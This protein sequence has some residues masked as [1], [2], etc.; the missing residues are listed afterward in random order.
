MPIQQLML[1]GTPGE[2]PTYVD[3]VFSTY[4]YKGNNSDKT[5]TN[6]IDLAGEGGLTWVKRTTGG[7]ADHALVDTLRGA[8]EL[9]RSN[10]NAA[11]STYTAGSENLSTFTS[12]GFTLKEDSGDNMF[13]TNNT[14]YLSWSFRRAPGFFDCMLYSG[15]N[16]SAFNLNHNLGVVPALIILKDRQYANKWYVWMKG[17]STNNQIWLASQ[18]EQGTD[19][20]YR[21]GQNAT[22]SSIQIPIGSEVN[23]TGMTNQYLAYVFADGDESGAQIFGKTGDQQ[24]TKS[25]TYTGDGST[26]NFVTVGFEP[27]WLLVREIDGDGNWQVVDSMRGVVTDGNDT[28]MRLNE[29][30]DN[31]TGNYL[32]FNPTG[33]ELTTSSDTYWNQDGK[34]YCYFAIRRPDGYVGKPPSS[35]TDVF[36]MDTGANITTIPPGNFDSGFPVDFA[37]RSIYQSVGDWFSASR[38]T[39]TGYMVPNNTDYEENNAAVRW[40]SNEGWSSWQ[41]N[42]T[43][44]SYMWKRHKGMD[45][46]TWTGDGST[47]RSINHT[48]NQAPEMIWC[49]VRDNITYRNWI[50]LIPG[51]GPTK[52]AYLN[53]TM[54]PIANIVVWRDFTPTSTIFKIGNAAEVNQNNAEYVAYLF[55][56]VSGICKCGSY[57]G[58]DGSNVTVDLGFVP[59]FIIIK[60]VGTGDWMLFDSTQGL[61][62]TNDPYKELNTNIASTTDNNYLSISGNSMI[63]NDGYSNTNTSTSTYAYYAHA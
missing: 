59:R 8:G 50:C 58:G 62:S 3:D 26:S 17:M 48:M 28:E 30:D 10:T 18:S 35:G 54:A 42:S 46:I 16:E 61:S 23:Y 44:L 45:V 53:T 60:K 43:Y 21:V 57:T 55:T 6:G 33:F 1:G 41:Q 49:K 63:I 36:T 40:D 51:A 38:L 25:G 22:S 4:L 5:I 9:L 20:S 37:L 2:V 15:N 56:S 31:N 29:A 24:I 14:N 11:R 27:Q 12:T 47:E 7:N 39:G 32:S 34:T 13:N 19:S 52:Y